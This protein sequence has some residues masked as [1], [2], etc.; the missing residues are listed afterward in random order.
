MTLCE[1]PEEKRSSKSKTP[2][3]CFIAVS[4]V[5]WSSASGFCGARNGFHFL[6]EFTKQEEKTAASGGRDT[7]HLDLRTGIV[8]GYSRHVKF[9]VNPHLPEKR[10]SSYEAYEAVRQHPEDEWCGRQAVLQVSGSGL[11]ETATLVLDLDFS[12]PRLWTIHLADSPNATGYQGHTV[13]EAQM[14]N[15]QWRVYGRGEGVVEGAL[16]GRTLVEAANNVAR[17]YAH[18]RVYVSKNKLEWRYGIKFG[19]RH[20]A[21]EGPHVLSFHGGLEASQLFVGINRIV[22]GTFRTGSGLCHVTLTLLHG[23]RE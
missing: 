10:N 14:V 13:A 22:G 19:G 16:D 18:V 15:R 5:L 20:G 21:L 11:D 2:K 8:R 4:S 17:R 9:I 6:K 1:N 23:Q 7:V 3:S 12:S